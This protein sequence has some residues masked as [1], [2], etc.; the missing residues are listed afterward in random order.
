MHEAKRNIMYT[1]A[2]MAAACLIGALAVALSF[3]NHFFSIWDVRLALR[4]GYFALS[5]PLLAGGMYWLFRRLRL[6]F[7]RNELL[8][9]CVLSALVSVF[10]LLRCGASI[11][12]PAQR[13]T[14]EANS[15]DAPASQ[16]SQVLVYEIRGVDGRI[17]PFGR[18]TQ[19]GAWQR[20][21]SALLARQSQPARLSFPFTT[22]ADGQISVLVQRQPQG[23]TLKISAGEYQRQVNLYEDPGGTALLTIPAGHALVSLP[24]RIALYGADWLTCSLLLACLLGGA[25]KG[26][27][28]M[29]QPLTQ[30]GIPAQVAAEDEQ[31]AQANPAARLLPL[32]AFLVLLGIAF[33]F[34]MIGIDFGFHWDEP[35]IINSV[36]QSAASGSFL[37]G[38]YN[39][40]SLSYDLALGR[41]ILDANTLAAL[42]F[43]PADFLQRLQG[44]VSSAQ[45]MLNVRALFLCFCLCTSVSSYL[46][47]GV[48][49]RNGDSGLF[50]ATL[51]LSSWEIAYHARWIAPDGLLAFCGSLTILLLITSLR[52]QQKYGG[53]FL[54]L[55]ALMAGVSM[56]AKY[57]GGLFLLP[58]LIAFG[59]QQARLARQQNTSLWRRVF[60]KGV[61]VRLGLI[62]VIFGVAFVGTTPGMLLQPDTFL[63]D[64]SFEVF[65]YQSGDSGN[66]VTPGFEHAFL[67]LQY[68]FL[69]LFSP[70]PLLSAGVCSLAIVGLFSFVAHIKQ[71][72]RIGLFLAFPVLYFLYI[73]SQRVMIVRNALV[74]VPF[75]CILAGIGFFWLVGKIRQPWV[76]RGVPMASALLLAANFVFLAQ[77]AFSISHR[78]AQVSAA[79][80]LDYLEKNSRTT[81]F[82]SDALEN[83][84]DTHPENVTKSP[85]LAQ[86]YL[87]LSSERGKLSNRFGLYETPY[88][89]YEVNFNYYPR[90]AG[91]E[92]LVV[93][94]MRKAMQT[95]MLHRRPKE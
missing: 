43:H 21:G 8:F 23:G 6:A 16:G 91:D 15:Q 57:Y 26:L 49:L 64:V 27:H 38:W 82:L 19:E 79:L 36:V 69:A 60:Q 59:V 25:R 54:A 30:A 73:T 24:L 71:D 65:H 94:D 32:V 68:F 84:L 46:I 67:L 4:L 50:S 61:L 37:P 93:M 28:F 13:F 81:F 52:W 48:W 20:E 85:L 87:F 76:R 11:P 77:A 66:T 9:G 44:T 72:A 74:L 70:Y 33:T 42:P 1:R 7:S 58:V 92:R 75:L 31:A 53:V 63:N 41:A 80:V 34:G 86:K 47:C 83:K 39:Y 14:L 45:Y 18:M 10:V 40:P 17:I 51:Y 62:L 5:V 88:G 29:A 3:A 55:A 89:A 35:K 90:W 22:Q 78:P 95:E 12:M 56:G 2:W